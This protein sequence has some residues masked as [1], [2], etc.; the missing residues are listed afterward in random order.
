[1][2]DEGQL[3]QLAAILL[4]NA[5]K[6][7]GEGG[8]VNVKLEKNQDKAL[9]TV[10]NTGSPIPQEQLPRIFERFYRA[11]SSRVRDKGGYGLGLAIAQSIAE[12]HKGKITAESAAG[13]GTTFTVILPAKDK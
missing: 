11:D 13:R 10:Y 8:K 6:Y 1:M 7:A 3:K 12:G 4:D 2:G 5:C 9:L